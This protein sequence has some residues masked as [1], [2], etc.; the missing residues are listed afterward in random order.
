MRTWMCLTLIPLFFIGSTG[1][2]AATGS[3]RAALRGTA[4]QELAGEEIRGP[5]GLP[6]VPARDWEVP[7]QTVGP[8]VTR[9]RSGLHKSWTPNAQGALWGKTI[10]LSPGHGWY[11]TGGSW[12]TQRGWSE[13]IVEDLSNA[14]SVDQFLV[15]CLMAAGAQIVPLREIDTNS[16]MVIVDNDDGTDATARGQYQEIGDAGLFSTSSMTGYSHAGAPLASGT[17]PFA[18]GTNRLMNTAATET[19]RAL[20]TLSVPADGHYNVY[21]SYSAW[22]QRAPDAHVIVLHP[23]GQTHY[24]VDQRH[25]GQT[26]VFLGRFWFRAGFSPTEGALA[27]ANDSSSPGVDVQV[28]LDAVRIGGGT[29]LINRT[30]G[31]SGKPRYEEACRYH[32]Q[33]AGAPTTVYDASDADNSDDVSCRSRLAAWLHED[34]EDSVFVSWHSN[35]GGGRGTSTYV[36]GPNPVDGTY[37]FT[38]TP[39]SD[40]LAVHIQDR[41]V[42]QYVQYEAGWRDRG[43]YS[44]YFG[45]L[46]PSYNN[47]MPSALLEILF[48]DSAADMVFYRDPRIRQQGGR[49]VCHAVLEYFAER[50]GAALVLPPEPPVGLRVRNAGLGQ[51]EV[52]WS[53]PLPDAAGGDAPTSYRVYVGLTANSFNEGTEVTGTSTMLTDLTPGQ[54]FFV[55]VHAVNDAGE[56]AFGT[57]PAAV[58]VSATGRANI[59]VLDGF[60]RLGADMNWMQNLGYT[61]PV[62]RIVM[63]RIH[64]HREGIG[65]HAPELAALN[66]AFDTWQVEGL[67]EQAPAW[68]QYELVDFI[69]GR[70]AQTFDPTVWDT[71]AAAALAG[72]HLLITGS[73]VTTQLIDA[74]RTDLMSQILG[75]SAMTASADTGI[76]F[77]AEGVFTGIPG[78]NFGYVEG[79]SYDAGGA[80]AF[81]SGGAL[82]AVSS[83][84]GGLLGVQNIT[85]GGEVFTFGFPFETITDGAVRQEILARLLDHLA[86]EA[87]VPD[88]GP[89]ID[90]PDAD[91]GTQPDTGTCGPDRIC[92]TETVYGCQCRHGGSTPAPG[93]F[94]LLALAGVFLFIRRTRKDQL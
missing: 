61:N 92:T 46:N 71:L 76:T 65:H 28:S 93:T 20:Y 78:A 66:M 5:V 83:S 24:R 14:E 13:G 44:A 85:P 45:E 68:E 25:H 32:A 33:F 15:P 82:S 54:G 63:Q 16:A 18:A 64:D 69:V 1:P 79:F 19:A 42:H 41:L 60:S 39:G 35:A 91:A 57:P 29:G 87:P 51:V 59:L 40:R 10:Y 36:Y 74:N 4:E 49:A 43:V 58:G 23:G 88:A 56:S 75:I 62:H 3:G 77:D 37:N 86:I 34:G 27:L 12:T 11:W 80:E 70:G 52:A 48:H 53:P 21:I 72:T 89:D 2:V 26:W 90:E 73:E 7:G 30:G 38:G 22:T 50:D 47:E 9:I 55:K 8:L 94:L 84:S 81:V 17:N 6:P 67:P 31:V